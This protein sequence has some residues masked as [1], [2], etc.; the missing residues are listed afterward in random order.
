[1]QYYECFE[2]VIDD[3][4]ETLFTSEISQFEEEE[5]KLIVLG[6]SNCLKSSKSS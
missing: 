2:D 6:L 3:T 5:S 4:K 1:M